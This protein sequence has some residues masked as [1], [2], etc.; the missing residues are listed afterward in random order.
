MVVSDVGCE[1]EV[2]GGV[3]WRLGGVVENG[4]MGMRALR[5]RRGWPGE[6]FNETDNEARLRVTQAADENLLPMS[7]GRG[8]I[9]DG[10][11]MGE[12]LMLEKAANDGRP[13]CRLID[14]IMAMMLLLRDQLL[15]IEP[16]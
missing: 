14:T 12:Q 4:R 16:W 5:A 10:P 3:G 1:D 11:A 8:R 9:L 6:V 15:A 2:S 7:L 13:R